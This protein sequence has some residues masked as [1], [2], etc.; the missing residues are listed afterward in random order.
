MT[1]LD[2]LILTGFFAYTVYDGLRANKGNQG[3]EDMLVGGRR[4]SWW[5]MGL[6]VMATQTSAITFIGTTGQAFMHD[7]R[8]IQIYLGLPLAMVVLCVTLVPFYYKHRAFTAYEM[9]ESRFGLRMRLATSLFFLVS[10]GAAV[11]FSIAAPSYVLSLILHIPLNLTIIIMGV[12]VTIYTMFGG[13][14]GVIRTDMKQMFLM[15][16]ALVF[17]FGW[18]IFNL[19]EPVSFG[20]ALHL[21]GA[22]GKL[23][24]IDVSFDIGDK[25][26]IWSG[27]IAGFFLMMSYFGADQAQ[28]QRYLT[29]RSLTDARMSLMLS[30]IFKIPM[31]FFILLLGALLFVFY[32]FQERPLVFMPDQTLTEKELEI[33]GEL[34]NEFAEL[35]KL[36]HSVSMALISDPESPEVRDAFDSL[37]QRENSLRWQQIRRLEAAG[38]ENRNDTN[39]VFP[40]FIISELPTG[41][42]GLIIAGILAAALSSID[43]LLNS[44]AASSILDWYRR[45]KQSPP[46]ERDDML[47]TRFATGMWGIFATCSA[48]VFGETES[49]IELVNQVGSFF[50]GAILGV[51]LLLW[52]PRATGFSAFV[53]LLTGMVIVGVVGSLFVA[54]D[55]SSYEFLL[56]FG[57]HRAGFEPAVE[58]LWLNPIGALVV[59]AIGF[60]MGNSKN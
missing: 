21:A 60:L 36:R 30:A 12:S 35:H 48:L 9:L 55:G 38:S 41:V 33:R 8:F 32:L 6:S 25:Y 4:M 16:F 1:I 52:V 58:Y 7:M 24:T 31:Q 40:F 3:L 44:L 53:G 23:E 20:D 29:A 43:S 10:R 15:V 27:I 54:C 47:L 13:I 11:G 59:V 17:I 50:Y 28:V 51:F 39:Y 45:L 19:P 5:A 14:S 26:N 42:L 2:W 34:E 18:L 37:N 46:E 57:R 49:I 56:P 22:A